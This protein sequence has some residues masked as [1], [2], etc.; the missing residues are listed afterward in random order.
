MG[1]A[2]E[3]LRSI[4]FSLAICMVHLHICTNVFA[5]KKQVR[6]IFKP[7]T[8]FKNIA[9]AKTTTLYLLKISVTKY[10]YN[11]LSIANLIKIRLQILYFSSSYLATCNK[12]V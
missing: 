1:F 11:K 4:K 10:A 5:P 9:I 12:E 3:F 7:I 6:L 2:S 8:S